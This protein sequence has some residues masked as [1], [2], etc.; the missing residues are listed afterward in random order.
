MAIEVEDPRPNRVLASEMG[1]EFAPPNGLPE[2]DF[3]Q[4][5][6]AAQFSGAG[7]SQVGCV[8]ARNL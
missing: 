5:H 2:K 6:P 7:D 1:A 3:W 4:G 8:H